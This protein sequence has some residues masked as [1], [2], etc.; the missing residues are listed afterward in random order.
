MVAGAALIGLILAGIPLMSLMGGDSAG[1]EDVRDDGD[2]A[3]D[4]EEKGSSPGDGRAD[5][6]IPVDY[7]FVLRAGSETIGGFRPGTDTL[8]ITADS[9]RMDLSTVDAD[10]GATLE[11]ERDGEIAVLRFAGLSEVPLKDIYL[12]I[13]EPGEAPV[14][15]RLS[16]AA[17]PEPILW[18]TAPD[19]PDDPTPAPVAETPLAP[20]DPD[21]PDTPPDPPGSSEPLLPTDPDAPEA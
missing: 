14:V 20:T 7:E 2:G 8:T 5:Q 4:A 3:T 9:W 19:S 16:E 13:V 17:E 1:D 12:N 11:V 6:D 10:E 15:L 18:P 21:T